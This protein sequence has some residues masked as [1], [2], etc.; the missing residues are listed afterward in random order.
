MTV[1]QTSLEAYHILYD[2]L[3]NRQ[4]EVLDVIRGNPGICNKEISEKLLLPINC[5]TGRVKELRDLRFVDGCGFK[6]Y[7]NRRVMIWRERR[8]VNNGGK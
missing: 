8:R 4:K 3:G 7:N 5:V 6:I 2:D 1:Q